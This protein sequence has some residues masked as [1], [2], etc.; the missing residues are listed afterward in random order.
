MYVPPEEKMLKDPNFKVQNSDKDESSDSHA[1]SDQDE[2]NEDSSP[3]D[4]LKEKAQES[5]KDMNSS[6]KVLL[7]EFYLNKF[8]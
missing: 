1:E 7:P 8:F 2:I 3:E 4:D 6:D 5:N